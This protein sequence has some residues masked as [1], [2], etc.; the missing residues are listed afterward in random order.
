ML[1]SQVE[2]LGR[3]I[4]GLS[5]RKQVTPVMQSNVTR[6]DLRNQQTSIQGFENQIGQLAKLVSE[7]LQGSYSW[8]GVNEPEEKLKQEVEKDD[9]VDDSKKE[10]KMLKYEKLLK[11]LLTNKRKLEELSTVE[12]NE[13]CLAIIHNKLHAKLK[14][15]EIFAIPCFI[16]SLSIEKALVDL[17]ANIN[18]MPYKMFKQLDLRELKPTRMSIQLVDKSI[19]YPKGIVE[20]MLVK[21]DKFIFPV[22]FVILDMG[23][24]VEVPL[25]LGRPFLA[26]TRIVIDVGN[27]KLVLKVGDEEVTLQTCDVMRVSSE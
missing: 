13:E 23:E 1:A 17:S 5:F 3:K 24:D 12:L 16:G 2:A 27:G 7:R 25:I 15:P 21:V 4:D 9:G 10:Q 19:K 11:E 6:A 8:K 18:L 22:D 20:D 26:T 14:D